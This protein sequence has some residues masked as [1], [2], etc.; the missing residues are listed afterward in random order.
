MLIAAQEQLPLFEI[1]HQWKHEVNVSL[2]MNNVLFFPLCC[3]VES[4]PKPEDAAA[5]VLWPLLHPVQRRHRSCGG[6]EQR[7]AARFE[8]A[9]QVRS[10]GVLIQAACITERARQ[11]FAHFQRSG[12]PGD[13]R[14]PVLRLRHVQRA[15]ED[16]TEGLSGE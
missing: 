11:G 8:D 5:Q 7:V 4:E 16:T 15:D 1:S 9:L 14:R 6:D 13:A 12:L 2:D 3:F 10:E